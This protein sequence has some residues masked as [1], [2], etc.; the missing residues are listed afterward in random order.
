MKQYLN[1]TLDLMTLLIHL[2]PYE[3]RC[4]G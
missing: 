2:L 4:M 1:S 3:K